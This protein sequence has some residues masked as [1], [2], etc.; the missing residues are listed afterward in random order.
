M[1][2][3]P[4]LAVTTKPCAHFAVGAAAGLK[5]QA[6]WPRYQIAVQSP[7]TS[8]RAYVWPAEARAP[9][10]EMYMVSGVPFG[11]RPR[12]LTS[13]ASSLGPVRSTTEEEP[14]SGH[15]AAGGVGFGTPGGCW[16]Q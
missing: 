4:G 16:L 3:L 14:R 8:A 2:A 11:R 13:G 6:F 9:W 7:W 1:L 5:N 15:G 12:S 10:S